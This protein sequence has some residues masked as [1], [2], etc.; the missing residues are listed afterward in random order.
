MS[1]SGYRHPL[2]PALVHFPIA[3]WTSAVLLDLSLWS[4]LLPGIP[5]IEGFVLPHLMLWAGLAAALPAV[6]L[7]LID[8]ARLPSRIQ[9]SGPM[10]LHMMSM[11]TAWLVFL[12]AAL[13]RVK[14]GNF[15]DPPNFWILLLETLGAACLVVGGTAAARIVFDLLPRQSRPGQ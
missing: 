9:D 10:R 15:A 14:A 2:H 11:G 7:G 1:D 13:W 3:F 12:A 8:Y 5:G 6:T 4:A